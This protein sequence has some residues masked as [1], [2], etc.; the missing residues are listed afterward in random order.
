[1]DDKELEY[2]IHSIVEKEDKPAFEKLFRHYFTQLVNYT[3]SIIG[4]KE[5][6][7]DIVCD[8]FVNLWH[9]RKTLHTINKLSYYLYAAAKNRAINH[10]TRNKTVNYVNLD[11]IGEEILI[12]RQNPEN[13]FSGK[14]ELKIIMDAIQQLPLKCQLIFRLIKEEGMSYREVADVMGLSVK[15]IENQMNI[16]FKRVMETAKKNGLL[17]RDKGNKR[18]S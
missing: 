12:S 14:Q 5:T 11:K 1:M 10:L 16:A 17:K 15:T 8:L 9:N 3:H 4:Q 6:S 13:Q 2:L 7:E 18:F